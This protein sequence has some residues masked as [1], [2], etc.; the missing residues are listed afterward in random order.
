[1]L[2]KIMH[3]LHTHPYQSTNKPLRSRLC[4]SC[5]VQR[6]DRVLVFT[7]NQFRILWH[8]LVFSDVQE[9]NNLLYTSHIPCRLFTVKY[10]EKKLNRRNDIIKYV[11]LSLS[12]N[13]LD[14]HKVYLKYILLILISFMIA[15]FN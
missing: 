6:E 14:I 11:I 12:C 7:R 3:I 13:F 5:K 9:I 1:M 10:H 2:R 4:N 8:W 15:S